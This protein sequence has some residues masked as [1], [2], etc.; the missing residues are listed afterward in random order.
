MVDGKLGWNGVV[1]PFFVCRSCGREISY[2]FDEKD[3]INLQREFM[4]SLCIPF[5]WSNTMVFDQWLFNKLGGE[6][7]NCFSIIAK[8][9]YPRN[10][11][12][13]PTQKAYTVFSSMGQ[14]LGDRAMQQI[15]R[16]H[17]LADNPDE[18]VVF[19]D[20][21]VGL[22]DIRKYKPL[23]VFWANLFTGGRDWV[24]RDAFWFSVTNETTEFCRQGYYSRLWFSDFKFTNDELGINENWKRYVVVHLRNQIGNPKKSEKKNIGHEYAY[25]I[26]RLL[27]NR[28]KAGI[29]DG[30]VLVGNDSVDNGYDI[31]TI[32]RFI[33]DSLPI[34]DLR[35]KWVETADGKGQTADSKRQRADGKGQTADDKDFGLKAIARI[36]KNAVMTIGRDS[37]IM[38]LA[39]AAGCPKLVSWDFVTEGWFPKVK[40]GVL[41]AWV[42]RD[43]SVDKVL[44]A[45]NCGLK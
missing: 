4:N 13:K 5:I 11:I 20:E 23:K 44:E 8:Q 36:C 7:L 2:S 17:Y 3:M 26:F 19:L 12:T 24:P 31:E 32:Q 30:V 42:A 39:G 37:G 6:C 9:K 14:S 35:N 34:V 38:Q 1:M 21:M 22:D 33:D 18:Q 43:S 40:P 10:I 28:Y 45:I 29:I 27:Q 16:D 15:I 41:S 25:L